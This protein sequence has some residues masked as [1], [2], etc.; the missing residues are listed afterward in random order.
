ML[1]IGGIHTVATAAALVAAIA[2]FCYLNF[3][4]GAVLI[5][6]A[7][8]E[9]TMAGFCYSA[10]AIT[11]DIPAWYGSILGS[12]AN[13]GFVLESDQTC[14]LTLLGA[15]PADDVDNVKKVPTANHQTSMYHPDIWGGTW[16]DYPSHSIGSA[17]VM[18]NGKLDT[19]LYKLDA[20]RNGRY[21]Q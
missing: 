8:Y 15:A 4:A 20:P 1:T 9:A 19:F 7:A 14:D 17:N 12:T 11:S 18:P 2:N 16:D 5:G 6:V 10:Y 21:V 13:D 3:V